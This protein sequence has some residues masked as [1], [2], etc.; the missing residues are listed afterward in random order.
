[1]SKKELVIWFDDKGNMLNQANKW[2]SSYVSQYGYKSEQARDFTDRMELVK[3]QEYRKKNT[4]VV[5]KSV[6]TGRM[7]SMFV[8]D[9]NEAYAAN[10]LIDN[11]LEGVW[12][13][14]KRGEGQS[15]KLIIKNNS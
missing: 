12:R 5:L 14:L 3:I 15:I 13:F 4:R 8:D 10:Q 7:Y 2:A 6:F 11:H 9:F 1:M